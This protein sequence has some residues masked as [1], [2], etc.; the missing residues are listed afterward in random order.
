M[1]S[2]SRRLVDTPTGKTGE[3]RKD[4]TYPRQMLDGRVD[5]CVPSIREPIIG[6]I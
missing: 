5:G 1:V 3:P 6:G 4:G 2:S